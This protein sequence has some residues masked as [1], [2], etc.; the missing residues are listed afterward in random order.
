MSGLSKRDWGLR[1]SPSD[2]WVSNGNPKNQ[3]PLPKSAK[4]AKK[5]L[6][7]MTV[8]DSRPGLSFKRDSINQTQ[9]AGNKAKLA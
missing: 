6:I 9:L 7:P 5:R 8:Q 4:V 3:D 2:G 1:I